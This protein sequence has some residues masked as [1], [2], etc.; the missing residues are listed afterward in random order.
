MRVSAKERAALR[1]MVELA[2]WYGEGPRPLGQI[3]AAQGLSLAY[4]EQI[5]PDLREAGLVS[6]VRGAHGGYLLT[7]HPATVSVGDVFYAVEPAL[8]PVDC[9]EDEATCERLDCCATRAVWQTL[10]ER[11]GETLNATSL[12]DVLLSSDA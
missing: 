1:A 8:V 9:L 5:V 11:I 6:S 2:R 4:L 3:A 12:A 10:A 7:R